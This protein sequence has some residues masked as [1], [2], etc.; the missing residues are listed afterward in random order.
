[1]IAGNLGAGMKGEIFDVTI[2]AGTW[3]N[4]KDNDKNSWIGGADFTWR[5]DL[6]NIINFSLLGAIN[7]DTVIMDK[8]DPM[9]N[10]SA[11]K[12][13]PF[14]FGLGYEYRFDLPG[15][16]VIKPY[17][18]VDL[19]VEAKTGE[20]DFEAGA[21]LQWFFRG[22]GARFKRNTSI[23][24]A[25]LGDVEI[26]AALVIGFNADDNGIINGILS[27]NED[28]HSSLLPRFGGFLDLELMNITGKEYV[29]PN[30]TVYNGFLLAGM[31]QLEYLAHDKI[32]PYLFFSYIPAIMPLNRAT[33]NPIYGRENKNL[34]SRLGCMFTPIKH[35]SFDIWYERID[36]GDKNGWT[37][38]KGLFAMNFRI[39][40]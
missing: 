10:P 24:G 19:I 40:L 15:R 16:M 5:P 14:A 36:K 26:P 3:K 37:P 4:G 27:I 32:M 8:N 33:G 7:Y 17:A 22:T 30:G 39:S 18:G 11:L 34:T 20:I 21:G 12:E 2:K 38:D 23:G 9:A 28:P 29:A 31:I 35:F 13:N 25:K 6:S 1:V